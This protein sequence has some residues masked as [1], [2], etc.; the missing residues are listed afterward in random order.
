MR[1]LS[2][3]AIARDEPDI[4][5]WAVYHHL[6]GF[7]RI[8]IYDNES[9]TPI[10]AEL[11][12][13][14]AEG[15]VEVRPICGRRKQCAGAYRDAVSRSVG[16]TRWLALMDIDE[17]LLPV[18]G[19][20]L[21]P[22]LE[23]EFDSYSAVGVNWVIFG[24]NGFR[25]RPSGLVSANYTRC[26]RLQFAPNE[27]VKSIVDPKAVAATAHP[28]YCTLKAGYQFVN[29]RKAPMRGPFNSPPTVDFFQIN[30]YFTKSF[31]DWTEK[32]RRRGGN[33]G[34]A[35]PADAWDIY[36]AECNA[37]IDLRIT[38]FCSRIL[39]HMRGF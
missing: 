2:L 17:F 13:L 5:E 38:R 15:W 36:N 29:G 34:R 6:A 18:A 33:S 7:E 26:S 27:H 12:D 3:A 37:V 19:D 14:V 16:E 22:I 10:T 35:R 21:R 20:D 32:L 39:E 24:S 28:H 8:L 9:V 11:A 23:R 31:A 1:Y 4:R 25:E 30:H